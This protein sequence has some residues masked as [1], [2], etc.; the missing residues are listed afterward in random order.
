MSQKTIFSSSLTLAGHAQHLGYWVIIRTLILACLGIAIVI[1]LL[2]GTINL[3]FSEI[4]IALIILT[5]INLLTFVR[6]KNPLPV[7]QMEFFIHLLIDLIALSVVFYY[8]G[9]ANNPFVSYFLV[10]IC[11]CAA[12]LSGRYALAITI[13]GVISYSLLLFFHIPLPILSPHHHQADSSL[14]L[15]VLGMWLNFFISACLITYF[16]VKM[17]HDLRTQEAQLNRWREDQLRD[18]QVMAVATLAAG[19]AHELGTPLSTMKLL[20]SELKADYA[21]VPALQS[22]LKILQD[23]V[24]QCAA[25][26]HELVTTAEQGKAGK[27]QDQNVRSYCIALLE[28][29]QIMRPDVT[30]II[31]ISDQLPNIKGQFHPTIAQAIINLL[32]NAA[33]ASPEN[34]E[35]QI[36]WD[37]KKMHWIIDDNGPG[38]AAEITAHIGKSFISTKAKGLGIGLLLTQATINRYGGTV[39]LNNRKEKGTRTYLELPFIENQ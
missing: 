19:T 38:I 31:S 4:L 10:P 21:H 39:E 28:R 17:A 12:T 9:G 24:N 11:I 16:I 37:T 35:I 7:T 15:H 2:N 27:L 32:N 3:P 33:D 8:S 23:Q 25:T 5:G 26:L 29:W 30:S 20:L 36:A 6:L 13:L 34:I 14:N 18:E 1:F 22:D